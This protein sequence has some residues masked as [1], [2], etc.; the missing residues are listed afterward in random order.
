MNNNVLKSKWAWLAVLIMALFLPLTACS[1]DEDEPKASE[2]SIVGEWECLYDS[3]GESWDEPLVYV[4]DEDGTGYQWFTSE[5][6][7]NILEYTYV[8]MS[9]KIRIKTYYG[10]HNLRYEISADGKHLILYG[11][12]DNDMEELYFTRVK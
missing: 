12:D 9:S 2:P 1:D 6:Y 10:V 3:Y 4:F 7:S 11:W 5:P 8:V